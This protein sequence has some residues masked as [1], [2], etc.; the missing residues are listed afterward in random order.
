M[1]TTTHQQPQ[2]AMRRP[3]RRAVGL[4]LGATLM[5]AIAAGMA[6]GSRPQT[7]LAGSD[8]MQKAIAGLLSS[9]AY[10]RQPPITSAPVNT[11]ASLSA[12]QSAE[13][14]GSDGAVSEAGAGGAG[15]AASHAAQQG[16][17]ST[18]EGSVSGEE[19]ASGGPPGESAGLLPGEGEGAGGPSGEG[20]PS[21]GGHQEKP[22]VPSGRTVKPPPV[23]HVWLIAVSQLSFTA[24]LA[25]SEQ[26]P[27]L[28][29]QLIPKGAL[30]SGYRLNA[31]SD[32]A[33]EIALLSG[34]GPN[35]ATEQGCPVYSDVQPSTVAPLSG[36]VQ[37]SGCEYP[38]AV[39]TLPDELVTA[40][41]SWRAYVQEMGSACQPSMRNP[42]AYF[43]SLLDGGACST[44]EV[45]LQQLSADLAGNGPQG[46][47]PAFNW[48][49]SIGTGL[50]V[51]AF[52]K[53]VVP[54]I[55]ASHAYREGGLIAIVPTSGPPNHVGA[56]LI[57]PFVIRGAR[58]SERFDDFS[59]LKGLERLFGVLPLGRS[60]DAQTSSF[61]A[62]VY[63]TSTYVKQRQKGDPL[64]TYPSIHRSPRSPLGMLAL[65]LVAALAA[66]SLT[67]APWAA[68]EPPNPNE[69]DCTGNISGGEAEPG[70]IEQQVQYRFVCDGP[71]TG[72]Q[73]QA[74]L[75]L[76][77]FAAAPLVTNLQKEPISD[78]F[79]CGGEVPGYAFNC[80]G[81]TKG[82]WEFVTGQFAIGTK[83]CSK[84][85]VDPLLTVTYAYLEKGV[86]TQAIS[87]PFDL[88]RPRHCPTA[89]YV[90][91]GTRLA[92]LV[93]GATNAKS[94]HGKGKNA[95][96]QHRKGSRGRH[97]A[98]RAR[99][100]HGGSHAS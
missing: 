96:R 82:P 34:Q 48:I 65:A 59:L 52:L 1:P 93:Q 70:S 8:G 60:A 21:G 27:Y 18:K 89:S 23:K 46:S 84:P 100:R 75:P 3:S 85:L 29:R 39:Q 95:K 24:A 12:Q 53:S 26:A 33:N 62:T 72:Y 97:D 99:G 69:Y 67:L 17:L 41:L 47:P 94:K 51:D 6:L 5:S 42:F 10:L 77:G 11:G 14:G 16:S 30:L 56:L 35:P 4:L 80:V 90:G 88:G 86:I 20:G 2:S 83:R 50:K 81:S 37:G 92:P 79:S 87:G 61:G 58:V 36:L 38:A 55:L 15:E 40:G 44:N 25:S 98:R 68:A 73:I 66:V 49:A 13:P 19:K 71:I 7:S 9:S 45:N 28:T 91:A 74:Q 76:T 22:A 63:R 54:E 57:S 32:L 31:A 64:H 43:H 78:S